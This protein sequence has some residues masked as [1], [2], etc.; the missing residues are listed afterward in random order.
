MEWALIGIASI[1][2]W[3]LGVKDLVKE[4][5]TEYTWNGVPK[6]KV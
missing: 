6:K 5:K 1:S 2:V 3:F 4:L